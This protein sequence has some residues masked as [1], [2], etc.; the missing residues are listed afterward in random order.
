MKC[1][2]CGGEGGETNVILDDGTGPW[3]ECGFCRGSGELALFKWL[4]FRVM[5]W[6]WKAPTYEQE[7]K[8]RFINTIE[9]FK[10]MKNV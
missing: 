5:F 3:D 6:W 9:R 2:S 4:Y 8:N 7:K 10:W 1:L